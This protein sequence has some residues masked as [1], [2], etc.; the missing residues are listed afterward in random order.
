[1]P[2]PV[3]VCRADAKS[4]LY[5]DTIKKGDLLLNRIQKLSKVID[6]E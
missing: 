1:V 6:I 4:A 5:Q 2:L 3:Y